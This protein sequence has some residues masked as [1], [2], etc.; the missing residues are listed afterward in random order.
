MHPE[1]FDMMLNS[2]WHNNTC[3]TVPQYAA[4][5]LSSQ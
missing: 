3:K 4:T 1:A 5:L 2:D